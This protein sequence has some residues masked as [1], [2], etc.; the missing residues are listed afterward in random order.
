LNDEQ[1]FLHQGGTFQF[2]IGMNNAGFVV[3]SVIGVTIT[4]RRHM[5]DKATLRVHRAPTP[6]KTIKAGTGFHPFF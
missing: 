1:F 3:G 5:A 4:G 2:S 6:Q